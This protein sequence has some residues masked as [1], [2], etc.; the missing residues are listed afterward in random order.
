MI[1]I[2]LFSIGS[3]FYGIVREEHISN[4][5][6]FCLLLISFGFMALKIIF[7]WYHYYNLSMPEDKVMSEKPSVDILT[8]FCP[9]EPYEMVIETLE[10]IQKITYPH[11]TYLCDEGNDPYLIEQCKRLD[12]IHVTR[13]NRIDAKAGNI[14]NALKI[15]TSEYCLILDPDHVPR[16][17]I[18]DH[19]I[20]YFEDSQIGFVQSV[21]AYKNIHEN[22]IAKAASQQTFQFYGPIMMTM[23]SHGTTQAIGANCIFRRAALDSIGG[24]APGLAEDMNT[25]I[26][27]YAKGWKSCYVPKVLTRG[28]A[29]NSLSAYFKQQL[30]WSRGVWEILIT[31]YFQNFNKLTLRQKIYYGL[32]PGHYLSGLVHLINFLIPIISLIFGIM[33]MKIDLILFLLWGSLYFASTAII[34]LYVQRWVME[35]NERGFHHDGGLLLIGT[36]WVHLLGL[37]YTI[38]RKKVPYIPTPKE[39]TAENPFFIDKPNV[40]LGIITIVAIVY[41]LNR[42]FN[43]YSLIMAGFALLN[44]GFSTYMMWAGFHSG[45]KILDKKKSLIKGI[46]KAASG[47]KVRFWMLRHKIYR[48]VRAAALPITLVLFSGNLLL[49]INHDIGSIPI[50]NGQFKSNYRYVGI[51]SP[52]ENSGLS[53]LNKVLNQST[54]LSFNPGII[55]S[56]IAWDP[57][58]GLPIAHIDSIY[59]LNAYPMITWEPW[60]TLFGDVNDTIPLQNILLGQ[61]D[62]Y[63]R[64]IAK[65]FKNLSR[66]IFLRYAHEPDNP[67]Y[68]WYSNHPD[69]PKVFKKSWK[70]IFDIFSQEGAKNVIWVYNPWKAENATAYFPGKSHT[71]WLGITALNYAS[72]IDLDN[73]NSFRSIYSPFQRTLAFKYD[74]PVMLAEFGTL[75]GKKETFKWFKEAA[76]NIEDLYPEIQAVIFFN[77]SLDQNL[78]ESTELTRLNW[79]IDSLDF[80]TFAHFQKNFIAPKTI[81]HEDSFK[82]KLHRKFLTHI[83]GVNYLKGQNWRSSQYPLFLNEIRKDFEQIK[84]LNM[85]YIVRYGPTIYD[86]NIFKA[87]SDLGLNI[88]YGFDSTFELDFINNTIETDIYKKQILSSVRKLKDQENIKAWHISSTPWTSSNMYMPKPNWFYQKQAYFEWIEDL[89]KRIKKIDPIRPISLEYYAED[90]SISNLQGMLEKTPSIDAI[91]IASRLDSNLHQTL[92]KNLD[93]AQIPYYLSSLSPHL[94]HSNLNGSWFASSWQDDTFDNHISFDGLLDFDGR[95]KLGYQKLVGK[96]NIDFSTPHIQILTPVILGL[97]LNKDLT[98][99]A[100]IDQNGKWKIADN[101]PLIFEWTLVK[102]DQFGKSIEMEK[103]GTGPSLKINLPEKSYLYRLRLNAHN[104]SYSSSVETTLT[105]PYYSGSELNDMSR[106]AFDE[107]LKIK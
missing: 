61:Y 74:L 65:Q 86:N 14:N 16:P 85:N 105:T 21:Q 20:P 57:N 19:L 68:P 103:I 83:R 32:V 70:H 30:K 50:S 77:S 58:E 2:G 67:S 106:E 98:Y 89:S 27:L 24:H 28:L 69:A 48:V 55:S 62:T 72:S 39:G 93:S 25:T 73:W 80:S 12:V 38:I 107:M 66:P 90:I 96:E 41:G 49:H 3:F 46:N 56:Y 8:T 18:L 35:E 33:P 95:K 87:A 81:N 15:A 45:Y 78:P 9:G 42:D 54:Q 53:N 71:D 44:I 91:G 100:L 23:N 29:P 59:K 102:T 82:H 6:L 76:E 4:L 43:P 79:T 22:L 75:K 104:Q 36:W 40:I 52:T 37:F 97:P 51:F 94:L 5:P 92:I 7:E 34:R 101:E 63:I 10:A 64:S 99:R 47:F 31:S 17:D 26:L 13:T 11:T 60:L 84:N 88:I 1:L